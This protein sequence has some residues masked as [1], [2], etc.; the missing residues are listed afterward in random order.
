MAQ[1]IYHRSEW[2]NPNEQWGNVYLNADLTNELYKRASEYENSWVTDQLLNGVGTKPSIIMT[3]T[4]YEDGILN[5][6]KPAQTFGSELVTNGG[7]DTDSDWTKQSNWTISNG[8]ANSNGTSGSIFQNASFITGRTYKVFFE[9]TSISSGRVSYRTNGLQNYF[10]EVGTHTITWVYDGSFNY[11]YLLSDSGFNGSIDNVSVKEVIDADFDFTRGSSATRVNEKGLIQDVQILS[12]E[13]V[14]NG[15]F[16]EIGSEEVTNGDFEQIGSE[17]VTNG[18]FDTDSWW[19]VET[20]EAQIYNGKVN[21]NTSLQNYGIYRTN[22]LTSNKQYK[23]VFTIDTYTSGAV[24]LNIGGSVIGSYNQI[25]TYNVNITGGGNNLFG[26]QSDNGGAVLSIDNVSVKEVGQDW[27]FNTGWSIGDGVAIGNASIGTGSIYQQGVFEIGKIYQLKLDATLTSGSFKL[28]GSGGSTLATFNETKSYNVIIEATQVDLMFRRI[29]SSFIGS[30]D[31]ISVKEVGQNWT[32]GTGWS[33]GDGV[34]NCDGTQTN[35]SALQQSGIASIGNIYKIQF[36]LTVDA[37]FINYVNLGG[38]IDTTNLTTSGTYTYY[39]STTT[40]TDNLGIAANVDFIGSID[41]VSVIEITDD[42][43]LPR[44]NYTNFDYQDVLGDE[45]VTN[46]DFSDGLNNWTDASN[47]WSVVN[48]QAYHPASTSMKQLYQDVSTEV[49]K[50]YKISV[51]VN[52]ISG[53][54]QVFWDK[55]SGQEGQNLAQ[56][57]NEIIVTTFKTN[58]NIYF[59]RV[60]PTNA[61]FYIDNV[62]VKELTE[63]VLVPYSGEGALLLEPSRTNYLL[64]SNQFDTTWNLQNITISSNETGVGGSV[65]AWKLIPSTANTYH[66]ITNTVSGTQNLEVTLSVYAKAD[67]Y[68]FLRITENGSTGDYAT[69]NL[70]DGIVENK[71]S[72]AAKIESVGNGWYRCSSSIVATTSHRF[73]MYVMESATVQEPWQGNGT[74]GVYIQYAQLEAGSYATSYIPTQGSA[75]TRLADSCNNGGNEQVINS[76]EGVLYAEISAL[77]NGGV[78][79]RYISLGSGSDVVNTV[80]LLYHNTANRV[81]FRV[82]KGGSFQVNIS[83]FTFEQTDNLKIAVKFKENDFALWI[84]GVERATDTSGQT[85]SV[86]TLQKLQFDSGNRASDF[87]GNVKCVAV[88]KEALSDTELQKLTQV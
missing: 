7:F 63:D 65:D 39:T 60:S 88:F 62:S 73:D 31:N 57:L 50:K 71:T 1:E 52:I 20:P 44:I 11:I 28:E 19:T 49:N 77:A 59:G 51:N 3:P 2:G 42:T 18:S 36:D 55:V 5:S 8:K 67:G 69:F 22:L 46:G 72:S 81:N 24:H 9:I 43:D 45:L 14:Q 87:Y 80:Q 32:F 47:W 74:S 26:I 78:G 82:T 66:R 84:N 56:G 15:N 85:F 61:E 27:E 16:E 75:V 17:L 48:G 10:S 33:I 12:D 58:S 76:T 38:W 13:L 54:P 37:G 79:D 30:I 40:A 6:V 68:N 4:A 53:T 41:N 86:G 35:N 34:A 70:L 25:G 21:F 29:T 83:D 23:V 64:Q